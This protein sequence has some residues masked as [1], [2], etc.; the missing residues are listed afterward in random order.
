MLGR[1]GLRVST[2]SGR[3]SEIRI[4]LWEA[5]SR[6]ESFD[7]FA[8]LAEQAVP[9]SYNKE[10]AIYSHEA[11]LRA[12]QVSKVENTKKKMCDPQ[13]CRHSSEE[14][15]I[16]IKEIKCPDSLLESLAEETKKKHS[17]MFAESLTATTVCTIAKHEI[18][19]GQST[20]ICQIGE[21]VPLHL[22]EAVQKEIKKLLDQGI[23]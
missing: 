23:I 15:K 14:Y 9:L 8:K 17:S 19:T 20:P 12:N 18:E 4:A 5:K 1:P 13:E 2:N 21:R 7:L 11:T 22:Q 10:G 6:V 16:L 3:P